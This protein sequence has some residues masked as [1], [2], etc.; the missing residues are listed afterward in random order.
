LEEVGLFWRRIMT[1]NICGN[2][3]CLLLADGNAGNAPSPLLRNVE[4]EG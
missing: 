2:A 1:G 4:V 3:A